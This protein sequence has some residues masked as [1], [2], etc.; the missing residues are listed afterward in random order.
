MRPLE[1]RRIVTT[2]D[3]RGE[4]DSLL[5]RAGADVVHVP[6]IEIDESEA[7]AATLAEAVGG[8]VD[9]D[10]VMVTSRHGARR[11][12]SLAARHPQLRLAAVGRATAS[13][14]AAAAGRPVEV[15]PVDQ[16]AEAL[17]AAMPPVSRDGEAVLVAQGDRAEMIVADGLTDRGFEVRTVTV[18]VNRLRR[19]SASEMRAALAADAVA[20]AS[21]SAAVAWVEAFGTEAPPVVVAIGP[22]TKRVAQEAGLAVTHV[23]SEHSV[24]GL[25][26]EITAVLAA[27]P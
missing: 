19:P 12:G 9:S 26:A 6:L 5:A 15:V 7:S 17:V 14:L 18:Y 4:L 20:F 21:G 24:A 11:V 22:S 23:A 10:W 27:Q 25:A 13:E 16:T 8:L 1:G 3:E 2:R